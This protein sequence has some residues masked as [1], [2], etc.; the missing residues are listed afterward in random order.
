MITRSVGVIVVDG[1]LLSKNTAVRV[2]QLLRFYLR[3]SRIGVSR[4]SLLSGAD[5]DE[6]QPALGKVGAE[7]H[8]QDTEHSLVCDIGQHSLLV[9]E[10]C[11][12]GPCS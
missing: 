7:K 4:A 8:N 1:Q 10:R 3:S 9:H 5:G 6:V 2:A 11:L 12:R